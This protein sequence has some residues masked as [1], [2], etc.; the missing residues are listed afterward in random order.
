[1]S[2]RARILVATPSYSGEV[3]YRYVE[4]LTAAWVYCLAHNVE[5]EVRFATGALIQYS[6]NQLLREFLQGDF[7]HILWLDADVGFDPRAIIQLL[8]H[9]KDVVGGV[10]PMKCMPIQWPYCPKPGED[11]KKLHR[12]DVLPGGFKLCSRKAMQAVADVAPLYLHHLDGFSYETPHVFDLVLEGTNLLGEDVVLCKK[13]QK[14]GFELWCDPDINFRHVGLHQWAGN[15][16]V[17]Y[18]RGPAPLPIE[19]YEGLRET[20]PHVVMRS[21]RELWHAWNNGGW[22]I[23]PGGLLAVAQLAKRSKII[24]EFGSG[25]STLVMAAANPDA[26]V[27]VI[28]DSA[29]WIVRLLHE[30]ARAGIKNITAH[31]TGIDQEDGGYIEPADLPKG[32]YDLVVVDGPV[33][34][35][36]RHSTYTR[37]ADYLRGAVLVIDDASEYMDI[38]NQYEHRVLGNRVAIC[39]PKEPAL[40]TSSAA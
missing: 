37:F 6:R 30:A 9:D 20:D 16:R 5:L 24:L 29:P 38:V 7:T 10:Y 19:A 25:V 8:D 26:Q 14:L 22:A 32:P 23:P 28:E 1:M 12:A 36:Q 2:A 31:Q 17:A 33:Q 18:E 15:L 39:L 13:L 21:C 11:T 3:H 35:L 40:V 27:H 4:S 34:M